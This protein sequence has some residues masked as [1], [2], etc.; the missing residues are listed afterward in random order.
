MS[1]PGRIV[2]AQA[3]LGGL[4]VVLLLFL[5]MAQSRAGLFA[6][7]CTVLPGAY[8]AWSQ[9]RTF[10]ATRLLFQGVM[11][12]LLTA[13]LMAVSIVAFSVEPVG[14]FVTF[15]VMQLGYLKR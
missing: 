2:V 9:Q 14:F 13:T 3:T 7:G 15:V 6:L 8:Y 11:R 10:H 5:D 4:C 12:M 1:H